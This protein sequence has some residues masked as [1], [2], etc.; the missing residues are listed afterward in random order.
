[1]NFSDHDQR[2]DLLV[3]D[4]DNIPAGLVV[5]GDSIIPLEDSGR[6]TNGIVLNDKL[7]LGYDIVWKCYRPEFVAAGYRLTLPP[8]PMALWDAGTGKKLTTLQGLHTGSIRGA[9]LLD[10]K[11]MITWARDFRVFVWNT[12]TGERTEKFT[13]PVLTDQDGY[14]IV[15]SRNGEDYSPEDWQDYIEGRGAPGFNVTIYLKPDPHGE[16]Y[17]L[18][19]FNGLTGDDRSIRGYA[20]DQHEPIDHTDLLRRVQD[21]EGAEAGYSTPFRLNDGRLGIGGATYG[22]W[23]QVFIWDGLKDLTILIPCSMDINCRIDGEIAP[24]TIRIDNET[25]TY[26]FENI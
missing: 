13:T 6:I 9:K 7:I 2:G 12:E 8:Y 15:S 20:P 11:H 14:A 17:G 3:H 18:G 25:E 23:E 16:Q 1:M 24:N 22:A 26:T 5:S 10:D 19:P 21:L 4:D